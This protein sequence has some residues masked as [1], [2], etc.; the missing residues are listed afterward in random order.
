METNERIRLVI[1]D[2]DGTV[3]NPSGEL[4]PVNYVA[5]G[6]LRQAGIKLSLASARPS[7]G[8]SWLLHM[9]DVECACAGLNG[10]ILFDPG[11][12]V[13]AEMPLDRGIAERRCAFSGRARDWRRF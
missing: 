10:A 4:S 11:S 8:M 5:A 1:S 9:L 3:L 2:V 6:R 13:F 7:F 12:D